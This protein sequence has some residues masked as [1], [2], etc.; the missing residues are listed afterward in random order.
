M[1][2]VPNACSVLRR[3]LSVR[4]RAT[5]LLLHLCAN[6]CSVLGGAQCLTR[7]TSLLLHLSAA[8]FFGKGLEASCGREF[9]HFA[10]RM[11]DDRAWGD[12]A[13]CA[14]SF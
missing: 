9:L 14:C 11:E 12:I 8:V 2:W 10:V 4:T 7:A 5:S 6:A 13:A 3:V 1:T